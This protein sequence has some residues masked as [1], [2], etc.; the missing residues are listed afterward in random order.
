MA[1]STLTRVTLC[2]SLRKRQG[3]TRDES[4]IFIEGILEEISKTLSKDQE[5]KIPLFGVFFTRKKN[6]RIGRNPKT[7]EEAV[8]SSRRVIS[9]RPSRFLKSLVN[10]GCRS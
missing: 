3:L 8:I 9:F 6:E 7:R 4:T 5:V 10:E 1:T 2:D